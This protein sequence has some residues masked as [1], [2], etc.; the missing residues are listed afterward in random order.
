MAMPQ[1]A[2]Q[3]A[4]DGKVGGERMR[5]KLFKLFKRDW[6]KT[7]AI[8]NYVREKLFKLLFPNKHKDMILHLAYMKCQSRAI[9]EKQSQIQ[10]LQRKISRLEREKK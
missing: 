9:Q 10:T 6:E 4:D 7:I 2:V 3:V 1:Q 5:E 8:I